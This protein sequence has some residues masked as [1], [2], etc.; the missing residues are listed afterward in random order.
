MQLANLSLT[1]TRVQRDA[2]CVS[3]HQKLFVCWLGPIPYE[4]KK[5]GGGETT[6]LI[7]DGINDQSPVFG[8][9]TACVMSMTRPY[10]NRLQS[11][12]ELGFGRGRTYCQVQS[13]VRIA[14][15]VN[16]SS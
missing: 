6:L 9:L 13:S 4:R 1:P 14:T 2:L 12:V 15:F 10:V 5:E 16:V 7:R 3:G 8:S 11:V